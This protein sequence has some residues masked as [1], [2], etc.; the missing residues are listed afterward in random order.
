[1]KTI[2]VNALTAPQRKQLFSPRGLPAGQYTLRAV[3]SAHPGRFDLHLDG[4]PA[5]SF[6]A[7]GYLLRI[8]ACLREGYAASWT[9]KSTPLGAE[10]PIP[11]G[12]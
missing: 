12:A 1:M 5:R 6:L 11:E 4:V 3:K 10:P 7:R 2:L 9:G 8:A